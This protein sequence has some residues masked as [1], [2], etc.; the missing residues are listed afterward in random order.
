MANARISYF[1]ER[2]YENG[3][4]TDLL[5]LEVT[6]DNLS[7]GSIQY[8]AR[9][10]YHILYSKTHMRGTTITSVSDIIER[11]YAIFAFRNR[12]ELVDEGGQ[13]SRR[14][15]NFRGNKPDWVS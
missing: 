9:N 11:F 15:N 1:Y 10:D 3:I 6:I 7:V 5:Y 13:V 14:I 4:Y 12:E 2:R 8:T